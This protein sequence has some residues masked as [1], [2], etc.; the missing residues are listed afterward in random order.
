[1]GVVELLIFVGSLYGL[2]RFWRVRAERVHQKKQIEEFEKKKEVKFIDIRKKRTAYLREELNKYKV[3]Q[4]LAKAALLAYEKNQVL[5]PDTILDHQLYGDEGLRGDAKRTADMVYHV[6]AYSLPPANLIRVGGTKTWDKW[7]KQFWRKFDLKESD[8]S[9]TFAWRRWNEYQTFLDDQVMEVVRKVP[10]SFKMPDSHR[11]LG[12]MIVA[13]PRHGKSTVMINQILEDIETGACVVVI[14]SQRALI[15]TLLEYVQ[16]DR[17]VLLDGA[18]YPY[19]PALSLFD[20]GITHIDWGRDQGLVAHAISLLKNLIDNQ[21]FALTGRMMPFFTVLCKF[22]FVIPHASLDTAI[23]ILEDG[24]EKYASH[25]FKLDAASREFV[26]KHLAAK[27][28]RGAKTAKSGYSDTRVSVTERF[29]TLVHAGNIATMVRAPKEKLSFAKAM[30][31]G[32]ILLVDTDLNAMGD[33]G[34]SFLGKLALMK[35]G[36]EMLRRRQTKDPLERVYLFVDEA[37]QYFMSGGILNLLYEQGGKRGLCTTIAFHQTSQV[38][39][40]NASLLATIR[41]MSGTKIV[42]PEMPEDAAMF[43]RDL[44]VDAEVISSIPRYNFYFH[45]KGIGGARFPVAPAVWDMKPRRKGK[46]IA[47]LKNRMRKR[48][49]YDP[50]TLASAAAADTDNLTPADKPQPH[51]EDTGLSGS[52]AEPSSSDTDE[53]ND[54]AGDTAEPFTPQADEETD[55]P[56][57]KRRKPRHKKK[58]PEEDV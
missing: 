51:V 22:L 11:I 17:L 32:K 47:A 55:D 52:E 58:K 30:M 35:L 45:C 50:S 42:A 7:L 57:R 44:R 10:F 41:G 38:T 16:E 8:W 2:Y 3:P 27:P 1:M 9:E 53:Q 39:E 25:L 31:P 24:Y 6:A 18:G 4:E 14:D 12:T 34:S 21:E 13:P 46:D 26:V 49:G 15:D 20:V 28:T 43:A 33:E 37:Q 5:V 23:E 40:K 29:Q 19:T 36:V 48:Y 56:A 54:L